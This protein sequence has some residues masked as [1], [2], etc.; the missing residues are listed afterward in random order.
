MLKSFLKL[1]SYLKE[2]AVPLNYKD[3]RSEMVHL[4]SRYSCKVYVI[5]SNCNKNQKVSTNLS[6]NLQSEVSWESWWYLWKDI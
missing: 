3:Q 5:F 1:K 2:N 6:K 4:R